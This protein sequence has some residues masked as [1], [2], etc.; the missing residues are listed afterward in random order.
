[1]KKIIVLCLIFLVGS[2]GYA[3]ESGPVDNSLSNATSVSE[4]TEADSVQEEED[5]DNIS[6]PFLSALPK[7]E[8][9]VHIE[10]TPIQDLSEYEPKE[11]VLDLSKFKVSGMVWGDVAPKA[12]INDNVY[13]VGDVIDGAKISEISKEGILFVYNEKQ[14]LL[15][16]GI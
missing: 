2:A 6:D 11:S 9:E 7:N 16:R 1:M 14:Y 15:K 10:E 8:P 13:G 5:F 4:S 3:D 12:I